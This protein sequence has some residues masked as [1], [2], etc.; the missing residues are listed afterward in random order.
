MPCRTVTNLVNS[1]LDNPQGSA[2][3]CLDLSPVGLSTVR[4]KHNKCC[5]QN[6]DPDPFALGRLNPGCIYPLD[7]L[8]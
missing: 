2:G 4:C 8:V 5:P 3:L 6:T 7:I 1:I